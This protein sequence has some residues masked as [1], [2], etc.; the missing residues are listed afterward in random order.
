MD[1][2]L[3]ILI[4]FNL[5]VQKTLSEA[6]GGLKVVHGWSLGIPGIGYEMPCASLH[7]SLQRG[8]EQP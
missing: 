5:L 1:P 4:I 8:P 7:I 3:H 6:S 2:E